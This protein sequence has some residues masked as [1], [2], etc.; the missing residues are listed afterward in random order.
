MRRLLF[1]LGACL[2]LV[3]CSNKPKE[4]TENEKIENGIVGDYVYLDKLGTLH[5]NRN[6][7]E[8]GILTSVTRRSSALRRVPLNELTTDMLNKCCNECIN[9]V[10]YENLK[11]I[12]INNG[13]YEDEYETDTIAVD[14]LS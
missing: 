9:D 7:F 2:L 3:A 10:M 12:C 14:S 6:C 5:A 1:C 13:N 8:I 4:M 11:Q